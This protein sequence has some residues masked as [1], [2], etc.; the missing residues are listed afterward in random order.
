MGSMT[1]T[2][3]E[4]IAVYPGTGVLSM[5]DLVCTRQQNEDQICG[6]MMID[7]RS[8]NP[9]WEDPVTMAVNAGNLLLTEEDR[10]S[11]GLLL[12]ASETGL[13]QE[14][15]LSTWIQRHL[16]LQ[17]NCR[18][19]EIKIACY[20]GIAA[21]FLARGALSLMPKGKK[22]LVITTDVSRMHFGKPYE[23][24]MGCGAVAF[25]VSRMPEFLT[26]DCE[27]S[28]IFTYE[29]ADLIRPTS[30]IEAGHSET[31]LISYMDG[32]AV[33]FDRFMSGTSVR[34]NM[35]SILDF[36]KIYP[37]QIYHAPFGGITR[38]AHK[39]VHKH[40]GRLDKELFKTDY[41]ATVQP[42][43]TLNRRMGGTYA[44]SVFI[45]M[46]GLAN[47][48][49]DMINGKKIAIYSYGSGSCAEFLSATYGNDAVDV[50]RRAKPETLVEARRK[51]SVEDYEAAE[52]A[53][54]SQVD[55]ENFETTFERFKD[56][57]DECYQGK[58]FLTFL[59]CKGFVRRYGWS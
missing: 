54:Y 21:L 45:S 26:I 48:I 58:S 37:Y 24:V 39:S 32:V 2:G 43:L 27:P 16:Q 44:S 23:F 1:D 7:E 33:T 56:W 30:K 19:A 3:I 53:R 50:A 5:R 4:K 52:R 51:L 59:G 13:D 47:E 55:L 25:I 49:G 42:S 12:V 40:F 20:G 41:Q 10:E 6:D 18:N 57:Y 28:G 35:Q 9:P 17:D 36:R 11:I 14:K 46:L 31:S 38:R 29:V 22:I 34:M 15:S 8:V